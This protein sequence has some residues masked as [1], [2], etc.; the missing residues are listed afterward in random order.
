MLCGSLPAC[1]LGSTTSVLSASAW[2]ASLN[3]VGFFFLF[4]GMLPFTCTLPQEVDILV[5]EGKTSLNV[6]SLILGA[7]HG[8]CTEGGWNFNARVC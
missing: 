7:A 3:L 6:S 1:Y 5:A 8:Y 4:W 2:I